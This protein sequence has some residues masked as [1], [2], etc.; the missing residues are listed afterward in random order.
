MNSCEYVW[1]CEFSR[2]AQPRRVVWFECWPGERL[3]LPTLWSG[4]MD[5]CKLVREQ[6]C[7]KRW[8]VAENVLSHLDGSSP[9]FIWINRIIG[10]TCIGTISKTSWFCVI[11]VAEIDFSR[12]HLSRNSSKTE[13][14]KHFT[15]K[16][17]LMHPN[18]IIP[19]VQTQILDFW[20]WGDPVI[21]HSWVNEGTILTNWEQQKSC[22]ENINGLDLRSEKKIWIMT[23]CKSVTLTWSVGSCNSSPSHKDSP[24]LR[25]AIMCLP[26]KDIY[27]L[28]QTQCC[29]HYPLHLQRRSMMCRSM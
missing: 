16:F 3:M 23:W 5:K 4:G 28:P 12:V 21:T 24:N 29:L 20:G 27:S 8:L 2:H 14:G 9:N 25:S 13:T 19:S 6:G 11:I 17:H 1:C 26:S 10:G 22:A 15:N 18:V 7:R